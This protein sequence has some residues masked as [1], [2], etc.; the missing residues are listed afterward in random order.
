MGG[1]SVPQRRGWLA[2]ASALAREDDVSFWLGDGFSEVSRLVLVKLYTAF[3]R[4]ERNY[5]YFTPKPRKLS[6]QITGSTRFFQEIS[7]KY[8]IHEKTFTVAG[9]PISAVN[10]PYGNRKVA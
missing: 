6:L 9:L 5:E 4:H 2:T 3:R 10:H 7:K 1:A 8:E